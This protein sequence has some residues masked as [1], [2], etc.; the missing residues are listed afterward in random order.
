MAQGSV[1]PLPCAPRAAT[2]DPFQSLPPEILLWVCS[3]LTSTDIFALKT[4]TPAVHCLGLPDS[5]YRRFLRDEFQYLPGLAKE[6]KNREQRRPDGTDWRGSFERL[7]KLMALPAARESWA[8]VDISLK[9]RNRIWK[10]VKPMADYLVESSPDMLQ[11]RYGVPQLTSMLVGIPGPY[12]G[13]RT[14]KEGTIDSACFGPRF[15]P[16]DQVIRELYEVDHKLRKIR[17]WVDGEGGPLC[18]LG[19]SFSQG[20]DQK[21][22]SRFGRRGSAFVDVSVETK[23]LVGFVVSLADHIVCGIRLVFNGP[24]AFSEWIGRRGGGVRKIISPGG[25]VGIIGFI[26]SGGFIETL[27]TLEEWDE[28]GDPFWE[29]DMVPGHLYGSAPVWDRLP[30]PNVEL[31]GP[32]GLRIADWRK[33]IREWEIW[34]NG[35]HEEGADVPP[36]G[37][38]RLLEI[39]GY[40]DD[41]ALRGLEF[42]YGEQGKRKR[43]T[44]LLGTKEAAKRGNIKFGKGDSVHAVVIRYDGAGVCGILVCRVLNSS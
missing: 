27:G 33:H 22:L 18:G 31:L 36:G 44:S 24:R 21:K 32:E 42:I 19:F 29:C 25:L 28:Y 43:I 35:F 3:L 14:G 9:N 41:A 10:I 4:A 26:N 20:S 8:T 30:P 7:R 17:V 13:M 40:Y 12:S 2:S 38:R 34:E 39:V 16:P 1:K 15:V 11:H 23:T 5:Y 37:E 6:V